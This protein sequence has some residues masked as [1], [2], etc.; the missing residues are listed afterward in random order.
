M[1][2]SRFVVSIAVVLAVALLC[3]EYIAFDTGI[4]RGQDGSGSGLFLPMIATSPDTGQH[5]GT[6]SP[7][8]T[9]VAR[10]SQTPAPTLAPGVTPTKVQTATPTGG[11]FPTTT[12]TAA[13]SPTATPIAGSS[14]TRTPTA[15]PTPAAITTATATPTATATATN[16]S[17]PGGATGRSAKILVGP[18][19]TDVSPKALVRTSTDRLFVGVSTCD[20][21]PCVSMAQTIRIYRADGP[22]IPTSFTRQDSSGEPSGVAQWAVAI[23]GNDV[24]HVLF[25]TRSSDAAP[26]TA[27][28]Y[29]TFDTATNR[30]DAPETIDSTISFTQDSGGQGVQSVALALDSAGKPHVVYLAGA[31]R[32][33][34]YRNKIGSS[35]SGAIQVDSDITYTGN[36]KAWHP[37]LAFDTVG[38][39]IVAWER[40]SFNGAN[41]G[42]IFIKTRDANGVWGNSINL[43]GTNAA[44]TI[45]DQSTSLLVTA[46]NRY[47]IAW[48]TAPDDYIRYQFSDDNGVTWQAHHPADGFQVTHNPSL[49]P[50]GKGGIRLY[51]HGVPTPHPDGHGD[52]LYY[53]ESTGGSAAW[54]AFTL[55]VTGAFDSSVNTRWS[56]FFHRSPATVD[57]AYWADPYPNVLY[58]GAEVVAP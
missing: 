7:V 51:G 58:V 20:A 1:V 22:G 27:L 41:D 18:G 12:P 4:G 54:S 52:N 21:Y 48:I 56:Q 39:I 38:R 30:W 53:F 40:G 42:T 34:M 16:T 47:H 24:I 29:A 28:K 3:A 23:D 19:Y 50:D 44:R 31:N 26:V 2:F 33:V 8:A 46:D 36:L 14:A 13:S 32:R 6:A 49:G 43:S 37:N 35:W 17:T 10:T 25:N 15:T 5:T 55:Y 9:A 57:I 11:T 45:I